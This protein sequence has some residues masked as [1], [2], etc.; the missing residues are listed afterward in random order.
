MMLAV[1]F[2]IVRGNYNFLPIDL[3]LGEVAASIAYGR[4]FVRPAAP[5]GMFRVVKGLTVL[6]RCFSLILFRSGT[7]WHS[8]TKE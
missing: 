4:L 2:H 3:V 6:P 7:S 8:L 5:R 1:V